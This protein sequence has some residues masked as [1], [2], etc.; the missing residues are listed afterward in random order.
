MQNLTEKI[1]DI[2]DR[3]DSVSAGELLKKLVRLS[4]EEK[5]YIGS[6][7]NEFLAKLRIVNFSSLSDEEAADVVKNHLLLFFEIDIPFEQRLTARYAFH[8]T[9]EKNNQRKIIKKAILENK[10]M[11]GGVTVG[12]WISSFDK[13]YDVEERGDQDILNF[14]LNSPNAKRL[15]EKESQILKKIIYTYDTFLALEIFDVFDLVELSRIIEKNPEIVTRTSTEPSLL[16]TSPLQNNFFRQ[17]QPD[18]SSKLKTEKK[19]ELPEKEIKVTRMTISGALKKY[20]DLGEQ[21]IT[22]NRIKLKNFPDPVRPSI[23]NWLSD[24]TFNA[25]YETHDSMKRGTYLFQNENAK[26]L[27]SADRQKL[28]FILKVFDENGIVSVNTNLKQVVFPVRSGT[29]RSNPRPSSEI[30]TQKKPDASEQSFRNRPE[31]KSNF[32][33]QEEMPYRPERNVRPGFERKKYSDET[34][35]KKVSPRSSSPL[36]S[37]LNYQS[38]KFTRP[39]ASE[40]PGKMVFTSPQKFSFENQEQPEKIIPSRPQPIRI[41]PRGFRKK[42]DEYS[43]PS[44]EVVTKN[45]VNLKE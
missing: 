30:P 29:P 36:A 44:G 19:Y 39:N 9:T 35:P 7:F 8:G 6:K 25:G 16:A 43:E 17:K 23:K 18:Y 34:S 27:S 12:Q 5:K 10:E 38:G 4:P 37:G 41:T 21:L 31:M 33:R 22:A 2:V 11:L 20:P 13:Q 26:V 32:R 1:D 28:A 3:I 45:V 42:S 24:Y 15:N 40:T 14:L